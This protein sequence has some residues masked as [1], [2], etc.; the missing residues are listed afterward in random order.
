MK[1]KIK[2]YDINKAA[3]VGTEIICPVCGRHFIKKSYQQVFCDFMCK[4]SYWNQK[5]KDNG[6]FKQY[7]NEHPE[8]LKRI[9]IDLEYDDCLYALGDPEYESL[10]HI[11]IDHDCIDDI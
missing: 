1:K 8:R 10:S 11:T 6:Y 4:Q 2:R 5:R 3:K 9:G 7:N